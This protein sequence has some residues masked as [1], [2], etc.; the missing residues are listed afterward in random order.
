MSKRILADGVCIQNESP[1][2]ALSPRPA[3]LSSTS[4]VIVTV[5]LLIIIEL[6]LQT[7]L[8]IEERFGAGAKG[9]VLSDLSLETVKW[10]SILLHPCTHG[11]G[12][13][14]AYWK[15]EPDVESCSHGWYA[16]NEETVNHGRVHQHG[17]YPAMQAIGISLILRFA[18]KQ[19]DHA[20]VIGLLEAKSESVAI[21]LTACYTGRV[22]LVM[23]VLSH[24]VRS[25][26]SGHRRCPR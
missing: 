6:L 22:A 5:G 20:F 19:P 11:G 9:I 12:H 8:V 26:I 2:S 4:T 21:V 10:W 18:G 1:C 23:Y 13:A 16:A 25:L 24:Q 14:N 17:H 7:F 3:A 15:V